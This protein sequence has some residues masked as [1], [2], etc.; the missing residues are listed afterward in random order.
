MV[1]PTNIVHKNCKVSLVSLSPRKV[2][3]DKKM[4]E[5]IKQERKETKYEKK[6]EREKEIDNYKRD[7]KIIVKEKV[8][9]PTILV[10]C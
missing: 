10:K 8:Q 1:M 5:K 3:E 6:N 2:C 4:R 7:G 9:H